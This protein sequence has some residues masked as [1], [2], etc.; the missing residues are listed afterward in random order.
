M[1]VPGPRP[2]LEYSG[3]GAG[4]GLVVAHPESEVRGLKHDERGGPFDAGYFAAGPAASGL[5]DCA[6]TSEATST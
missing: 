5:R 2:L 4:A 1:A 6:T 3:S